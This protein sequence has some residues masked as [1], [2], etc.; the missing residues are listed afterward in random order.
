[1]LTGSL[2]LSL[3]LAACSTFKPSN[4]TSSSETTPAP[5]SASPEASPKA[6]ATA[7]TTSELSANQPKEGLKKLKGSLK[8]SL[9]A[10]KA[11]DFDKAKK[12]FDTFEQ[13][14]EKIEDG[15][16]ARSAESYKAIEAG[17]DE[18]ENTLVRPTT[19]DK[20]KAI[21]ALESFSKTVETQRSKM[22]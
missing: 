14:W 13:G 18:V 8:R 7:E 9:A 3:T 19:P 17:M 6:E 10:V 16:K 5:T 22:Q 4:S 15:V 1:M 12:R 2:L 11:G 20:A 21:A